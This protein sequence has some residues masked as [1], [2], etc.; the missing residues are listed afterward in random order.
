MRDLPTFL[1]DTKDTLKVIEEINDKI[2]R[3][4]LSLDGVE[5][6]YSNMNEHLG[7]G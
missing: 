2:E 1:Q 5:K 3:Q 7:T 6:M 4:E